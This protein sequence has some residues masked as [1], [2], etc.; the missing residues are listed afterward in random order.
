MVERIGKT[1]IAYVDESGDPGKAKGSSQTFTLGA[2]LIDVDRW[3]PIDKAVQEFRKDIFR[4]FEIPPSE[5]IKA[6][7]LI[8]N[9][10][11]S[12]CY[13]LQP[14]DRRLIDKAQFDFLNS[15]KVSTLSVIG[16]KVLKHST[17]VSYELVWKKLFEEIQLC[18]MFSEFTN[19]LLFHDEGENKLIRKIARE[20]RK[21]AING[22]LPIQAIEDPVPRNSHHSNFIQFADLIA[23]SSWRAFYEP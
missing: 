16:H 9:T 20:A 17:Q 11:A 1:L 23:Y 7:T 15:N 4:R 12:R 22:K 5:E 19:F 2:L 3:Q 13:L 10:Q 18:D 14:N 8:R 6:K 21:S